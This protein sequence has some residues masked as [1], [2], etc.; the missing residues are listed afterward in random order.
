MNDDKTT[1][2]AKRFNRVFDYIEQNLDDTLLLE[3]LSE[4]AHFSPFHFHRQFTGYCGIPV[5]RYVQLMRLK[6]AS[7]RLAFNPLE[8]IIDIA[9]DAG[10]QNPESFSRAFRH[11]FGV[12]PSQFRKKPAWVDWHQR[13]P[14][15]KQIRKHTMKV[16][17]ID[18]PE[19]RVATLTHQGQHERLNETAA[20]FIEWR[21]TTGLSPVAIS[22][23]Y[24]IAPHDPATTK[25]EDFRF[26]FS[27]SVTAPVD[28]SNPFG[29]INGAIPAGRCAMIR[30]NGSHDALGE[31]ARSLY[32]DWLPASGE[33]LRDFPLYF[34]YFNF[35]HEV[36]AH[37][38][39]TDIYLPLK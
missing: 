15:Q 12:T 30:H 21:K 11:V 39:V 9:L 18:F 26:H 32:R 2:Y 36:P 38:L 27:G 29:V 37:E 6:R 16:K 35:V 24:G 17:I 13:I 5:G 23:T 34:Q 22:Q 1:V 33:E 10:F 20:R 4:V 7:Y 3:R 25:A 14:E 19:T 8:K 28:E 31:I